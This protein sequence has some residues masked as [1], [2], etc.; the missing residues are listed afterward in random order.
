M[1]GVGVYSSG[2][3]RASAGRG[4]GG[5]AELNSPGWEARREVSWVVATFG[6]VI[7][8]EVQSWVTARCIFVWTES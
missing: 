2:W 7:W 6:I 8:K 4:V 5:V 3:A 1:Q